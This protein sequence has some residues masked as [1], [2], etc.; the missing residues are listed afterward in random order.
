[1]PGCGGEVAPER[2]LPKRRSTHP[3]W[4]S[5]SGSPEKPDSREDQPKPE[6]F[7]TFGGEMPESAGLTVARAPTT[8][9]R[10]EPLLAWVPGWAGG[11]GVPRFGIEIEASRPASEEEPNLQA[12][13]NGEEKSMAPRRALLISSQP[14]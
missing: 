10:P 4:S 1:M 6:P 8:T 2:S 14:T 13:A 5:S 11:F 9:G 7:G 3:S 12:F